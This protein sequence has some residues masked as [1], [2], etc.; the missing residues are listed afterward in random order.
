MERFQTKLSI[1][2]V[3]AG[4][5]CGVDSQVRS[6]DWVADVEIVNQSESNHCLFVCLFYAGCSDDG[7]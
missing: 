7:Y 2:P 1:L 3:A 5:T 6:F 4:V